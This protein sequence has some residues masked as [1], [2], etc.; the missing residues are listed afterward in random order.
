MNFSELSEIWKG[1]L[2]LWSLTVECLLFYNLTSYLQIG[3]R[4]SHVKCILLNVGCLGCYY[5]L[6]MLWDNKL[7]YLHDLPVWCIVMTIAA[8]TIFAVAEAIRISAWRKSHISAMSI[9]EAMDMLP[10]GLCFAL[11]NGRPMLVNEKMNEIC[12][13]LFGKSLLD[14]EEFWKALTEGLGEESLQGGE[15]P[16]IRLSDGRVY[17]MRRSK[18]TMKEGVVYEITATDLT[19]EQRMTEELRKK[20]KA[21][22]VLNVRL[23]SLLGTIE[24]VTMSREL[25]GMKA[26]LHDNLGRSLLLVKRYL[27]SPAT[28]DEKELI[29]TWQSNIR[30][31]IGESPE[32]WQVP[33]FVVE[34]EAAMLGIRLQVVGKLPEDERLLP[35]ID[36]AISTHVINVLKHAEGDEATVRIREE[37]DFYHLSFTN[38]GKVPEGEI[39]ET[40][41]LANLRR[42]VEMVGGTME[43]TARPRF[44]MNVNLPAGPLEEMA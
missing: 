4:R 36:K 1:S 26:A 27:V 7:K 13:S 14:A 3:W 23:K 21:A 39:R 41:G 17:G 20:Q 11:Q 30:H 33:Y 29:L 38:N 25:L 10:M 16:M 34:K 42:E 22:K 43:V 9:K 18:L 15:Q 40:G 8:F 35:V 5:F 44:Q 24:Y 12:V 28:V 37:N 32:N 19:Q 2:I 6:C 31:L